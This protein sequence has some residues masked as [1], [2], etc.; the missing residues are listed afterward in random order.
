MIRLVGD[1]VLVALPPREDVTVSAGGIVLV[2]DP[3]RFHTP[4]RGIVV[5][6]GEKSGTVD[7]DEV[8]AIFSELPECSNFQ[9]GA[10]RD[11]IRTLAPAP[12]DVEVG[13]CVIFPQS[14]GEEIRDGEIDYVVLMEHEIIGVV[15]PSEK[16]A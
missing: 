8:M 10:V 2:K 7:L 15:E 12:F 14:A 9:L 11:E 6:L 1:R 4:T 13:D 16:V 5:A 3:D